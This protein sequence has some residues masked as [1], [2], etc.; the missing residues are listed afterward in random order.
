[1]LS[2]KRDPSLVIVLGGVLA[3]ANTAQA[4]EASDILS[5]NAGPLV[6][7]PRLTLAEQY[8]DNLFYQSQ[9]SVHDFITV[10]HPELETWL[11]K[12]QGPSSLRFRYGLDSLFYAEN[13][14]QNS[15]DHTFE[16]TGVL[17]G[18]RLSSENHYTFQY[19]SSI[20]GGYATTEQ[21]N[22]VQAETV[23]R[24]VYDLAHTVGYDITERTRAYLQGTFN[25]IDF[26]KGVTL[27]D[28][29]TTRGTVGFAF[30]ALPKTSFLGEVYYSQAAAG[31]NVPSMAKGPHADF[32]GG[33]LGAEGQFTTRLKGSVRVGYESSE[34]ADGSGGST[35]PV[36]EAALTAG[37]T[38]KTSASLTYSRRDTLS[39]QYARQALTSDSVGLQFRQV[40]GAKGRLV[41]TASG[42]YAVNDYGNQGYFSGRSDE[43]FRLGGALTYHMKLWLR[44]SLAYE[45]EKLIS[46]DP[47][48]LDYDVNRVTLSLA[49]GY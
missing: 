37:F 18:A 38:E 6:F 1:M 32:V 16:L 47:R 21:G 3:A 9:G 43:H 41:A 39:V 15:T 36:V 31:P 28:L 33:F 25:A 11:G 17:K 8:N 4:I 24:Y 46:S 14:L 26:S 40:F 49:I 44:A 19:L 48:A 22:I 45:Y 42:D 12:G 27:M 29:N 13:D 34:F 35:S 23:D 2:T 20:Y 10:V 5:V 7:R 30:K